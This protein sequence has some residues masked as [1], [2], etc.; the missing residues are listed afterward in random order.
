MPAREERDEQRLGHLRRTDVRAPDLVRDGAGELVDAGEFVVGG[1]G[2]HCY[3]R[4]CEMGAS[5]SSCPEST[6]QARP[7]SR[8]RLSKSRHGPARRQL[9]VRRG[10]TAARQERA[11][12]GK[13]DA[14]ERRARV[15]ALSA[16]DTRAT[17]SA[18]ATVYSGSARSDVSARY[19][20][21]RIAQDA[22]EHEQRA[23]V[24]CPR[25]GRRNAPPATSRVMAPSR[26][27]TG[28][29]SAAATSACGSS[30]RVGRANLSHAPSMRGPRRTGSA[31]TASTSK[32]AARPAATA[33]MPPGLSSHS[34]HAPSQRLSAWIVRFRRAGVRIVDERLRLAGG[35]DV[36]AQQHD[37]R[38]VVIAIEPAQDVR[39]ELDV[40]VERLLLHA[41]DEDAR[42]GDR[43]EA[44]GTALARDD[45][46]ALVEAHHGR[47]ALDVIE[48]G[49]VVRHDLAHVARNRVIALRGR[50]RRPQP[51]LVVA[52][53]LGRPRRAEQPQR[54]HRVLAVAEVIGD[55]DVAAGLHEVGEPRRVDAAQRVHQKQDVVGAELAPLRARRPA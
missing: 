18:S 21:T 13:H 38:R 34:L 42:V 24:A 41:V 36:A 23:A 4:R 8:Y 51:A 20:C 7:Q 49:R 55:H 19:T 29:R 33:C 40:A 53:G 14:S 15:P 11:A 39:G 46:G 43:D 16:A 3:V 6:T 1:L 17:S 5:V 2:L 10:L 50:D 31:I 37:V 26:S 48:R 44:A 32:S 28:A 30:R 25:D 47:R 52:A 27:D 9:H 54:R 35:R 45:E 12:G 22:R